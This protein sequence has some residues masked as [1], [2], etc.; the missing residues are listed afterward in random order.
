MF[1]HHY[2]GFSIVVNI[3]FFYLFKVSDYL[4]NMLLGPLQNSTL[5][6]TYST[7]IQTCHVIMMIFFL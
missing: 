1:K 5:I 7:T 2:I 6:S 4:Q 3:R